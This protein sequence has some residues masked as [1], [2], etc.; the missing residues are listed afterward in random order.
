MALAQLS[1]IHHVYSLVGMIFAKQQVSKCRPAMP[2]SLVLLP[3]AINLFLFSLSISSHHHHS[4]RHSSFLGQ[5]RSESNHR[6]EY[7]NEDVEHRQV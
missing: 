1:L 6:D 2:K 5:L 7:E 3:N 4:H